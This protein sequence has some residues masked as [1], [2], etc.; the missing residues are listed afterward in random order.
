MREW[1]ES[2]FLLEKILSQSTER[3]RRELSCAVLQKFPVAKKFLDERGDGTIKIFRRFFFISQCRK[4]PAGESL[5]VSLISGIEK[6]WIRGVGEYQDFPS[7]LLVSQCRNFS[8][9]RGTFIVSQFLGIE[10]KLCFRV[11]RQY[12]I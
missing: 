5:I 2:R 6:V 9:L 4:I 8:F 10:N 11:L 1:G 7:K 3:L 12:F